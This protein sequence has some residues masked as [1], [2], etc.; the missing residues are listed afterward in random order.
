MLKLEASIGTRE[1]CDEPASGR[2]QGGRRP[3]AVC[4]IACEAVSLPTWSDGANA[5]RLVSGGE[6]ASAGRT[7]ARR[8]LL[9]LGGTPNSDRVQGGS[10]NS[11]RVQGGSEAD[12]CV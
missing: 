8:C 11:D 10:P 4:L 3:G 2:V 1:A 9:R 12:S 7:V 6:P 5:G